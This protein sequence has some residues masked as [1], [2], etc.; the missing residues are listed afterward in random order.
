MSLELPKIEMLTF[1][2]RQI[3]GEILTVVEIIPKTEVQQCVWDKYKKE[4]KYQ[5]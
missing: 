5:W 4:I 3:E 1:K 2:G